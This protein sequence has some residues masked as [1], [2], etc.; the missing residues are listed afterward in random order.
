MAKTA[1]GAWLASALAVL[2]FSYAGEVYAETQTIH[3]SRASRADKWHESPQNSVLC[4]QTYGPH[5]KM[6]F[7][8]IVPKRGG[9]Y[10]VSLSLWK[11][12]N[13]AHLRVYVDDELQ[14][15]VDTFAPGNAQVKIPVCKRFF[16]AGKHTIKIKNAGQKKTTGGNHLSIIGLEIVDL[17][18]RGKWRMGKTV[19]AFTP[20]REEDASEY[21]EFL[22]TALPPRLQ[23]EPFSIPEGSDSADIFSH[24]LVSVGDIPFRMSS[25]NDVPET[26]HL[27]EEQKPLE[28]GLPDTAR[29][30][31]LLVW[32]KIPPVDGDS[33][34]ARTPIAPINQSERFTAQIAYEDGTSDHVIPFNVIKKYYGLDNGLWLYVLHP[35]PAK[36]P[37]RLVFH[38]K[39]VKCS[40]AVV[41]LTCNPDEPISPEPSPEETSAWYPAIDKEFPAVTEKA[42]AE[43]QKNSARVSDGIIAAEVGLTNGVQWSRLGSPAVG[44]V[45][46]DKSPVFAIRPAD[47]TGAYTWVGS[48][49]WKV[50]ETEATDTEV[51]VA[52]AYKEGAVDLK[53]SV[54]LALAGDGK[55]KVGLTLVNQGTQPFMGRV[56][57]PILEGLRLGSL[58]DTW[59]FLPE[60]GRAM[61]HHAEANVYAS[62]GAGHPL[63]VDSFFNPKEWYALTLLSNDLEG[64]FRWYD[65]GKSEEGGWYRL[66]YLERLL[67]PG[68]A[69]T[70][71]DC[72]VAVSPGDWRESFRLYRD[73]VGTWYE[74]K[75]PAQDWYKN[76]FLLGTWYVYCGLEN[77]VAGAERIRD[78]FGYCDAMVLAGWHG[79]RHK[80]NPTHQTEYKTLTGG[81]VGDYL[82]RHEYSGEYDRDA[83]WVVGGEENFK[84]VISKALK[85]GF[86]IS[87]YTNAMLINEGA[88][89]YGAKQKEWTT[90][91]YRP[92]DYGDMM[93]YL[94]C[95]SI[96]EWQDYMVDCERFL[97]QDLGIKIIYLDQFGGGST[98]CNRKDHPHDS[99]EPFYY[100]EREMTRRI[101]EAIP[102]DA[103]ICSEAQPEDTRLQFQNGYYQSGILSKFTGGIIV[104]MNMVRFAFPDT[105]CFNNIYGYVQNDNNWEFLKFLLM[106]GDSY[107]MPRGYDPEPWFSEEAVRDFGK[108]F[109]ILHENADAFMSSD[110]EPLIPTLIPGVSAN[111]FNGDEKVIWTVFNANYRT[112]RGRLLEIAPKPGSRYVDL[113]NDAPVSIETTGN[114]A[115][116]MVE[117]GPRAVACISEV[118]E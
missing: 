16:A 62:H 82:H 26:G 112:V 52:L 84:S 68:A 37:R 33:G 28:I 7:D 65:V 75:P 111:R 70:F 88:I 34:P 44:E 47:S 43:A 23:E 72:I 117:I 30:L 54:K 32:S 25:V 49:K 78:L 96:K 89:P 59:Y 14:T 87:P 118:A 60:T 6:L 56:R 90:G 53:A 115:S 64:Q 51:S 108:V 73:W 22:P 11:V 63:Q 101:R 85:A 1:T 13:G 58:P 50:V 3:A 66:E 17:G 9:P 71:P 94:P 83:L 38:D 2:L 97:T 35:A 104:P 31:F 27:I 102:E 19:F 21:G 79:R 95:L 29:E 106:S 77:L 80:D 20:L 12:S 8:V 46:L 41:A 69:W 67:K 40:F 109:R 5:A 45:T 74:P 10:E 116:L 105:K 103:V 93:G 48:D 57:F 39:V 100:G 24:P 107:F 92:V 99:P 18:R 114:T 76:S 110:V 15:E 81:R 36:V 61:I 113:W 91:G 55:M 98:T 4:M 86:P 42:E